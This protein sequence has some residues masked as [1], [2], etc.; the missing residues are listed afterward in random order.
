M[1]SPRDCVPESVSS[2]ANRLSGGTGSVIGVVTVA[3]GVPPGTVVS[4]TVT[5]VG[6]LVLSHA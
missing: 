5:I 6:R 2:Q 3:V 4:G 1:K